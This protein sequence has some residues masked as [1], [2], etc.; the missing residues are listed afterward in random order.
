MN[1]K[2][3][4]WSEANLSSHK[5]MSTGTLFEAKFAR[6]ATYSDAKNLYFCLEFLPG[7]ELFKLLREVGRFNQKT[8]AF[9]AAEICLAFEF[10]HERNIAYRDLKPENGILR[11]SWF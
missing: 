4:R 5:C 3:W 11:S 10:L 2:Y 9:Y 7:G 6:L 8:T 1:E